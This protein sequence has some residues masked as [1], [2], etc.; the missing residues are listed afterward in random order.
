[1]SL[2]QLL[3]IIFALQHTLVETRTALTELHEQ[4]DAHTALLES[5]I[6]SHASALSEMQAKEKSML[7]DVTVLHAS[8]EEHIQSI[9]SLS[10]E[11]NELEQQLQLVESEKQQAI[12][13]EHESATQ[14]LDQLTAEYDSLQCKISELHQISE[15]TQS[16]LMSTQNLLDV[17]KKARISENQAWGEARLQLLQ[18]R[19]ALQSR[20]LEFALVNL[21]TARTRAEISRS[22]NQW[23][24]N[25][26]QSSQTLI[27][28]GAFL[29]TKLRSKRNV[30]FEAFA[31]W[32]TVTTI[33]NADEVLN[34][35]HQYEPRSRLDVSNGGYVEN[36]NGT[37]IL[38]GHF[39]AESA[40]GP[41][42]LTPKLLSPP[43]S[44]KYRSPSQLSA[45][46]Y[47]PDDVC[48]PESSSTQEFS[49]I[50]VDSQIAVAEK[51]M[52]HLK[53]CLASLIHT[54]SN[55]HHRQMVGMF[56]EWRRFS[57]TSR[58]LEKA[59]TGVAKGRALLLFESLRE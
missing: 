2:L 26:T 42:H 50:P 15:V 49:M 58:Q 51:K 53:L 3:E 1:V 37:E 32:R 30:L 43:G 31:T 40:L 39:G 23:R 28:L 17:E 5:S 38:L 21:T 52:I 35:D 33:A 46:D 18:D 48:D 4:N 55:H 7:V 29:N 13:R 34:G 44:F 45:R 9:R 12:D 16:D 59:L 36:G 11:K 20:F 6:T 56:S 14:K 27:L 22:F 19:D 57:S 54:V 8:I 47:V 41:G 25:A 10:S 24:W